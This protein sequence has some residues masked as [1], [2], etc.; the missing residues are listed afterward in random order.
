MTYRE[1]L[2]N[3]LQKSEDGRISGSLALSWFTFAISDIL[4]I[5]CKQLIETDFPT[6]K[7]R[8]EVVGGGKA[9]EATWE[10]IHGILVHSDLLRSTNLQQQL[11]GFY[12]Y[13]LDRE[14]VEDDYEN[15]DWISWFNIEML[16]RHW[17]EYVSK[18]SKQ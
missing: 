9:E 12:D 18:N 3:C 2:E 15:G 10:N 14:A 7:T 5:C 13:L 4:V 8:D 11:I 16:I 1:A 6:A 17:N